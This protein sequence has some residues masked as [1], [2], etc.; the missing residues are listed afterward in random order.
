MFGRVELVP[1]PEEAHQRWLALPCPH[2]PSEFD[3]QGPLQGLTINKPTR[4]PRPHDEIDW[5]TKFL[6]RRLE[7]SAS[8]ATR[9]AVPTQS[10]MV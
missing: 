5:I 10:I 4:L 7:S 2:S 1:P 8:E 3:H 9:D 6:S